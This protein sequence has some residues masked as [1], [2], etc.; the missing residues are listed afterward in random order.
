MY[1]RITVGHTQNYTSAGK[2]GQ[3]FGIQFLTSGCVID[4][5]TLRITSGIRIA[6][7]PVPSGTASPYP[8]VYGDLQNINNIFHIHNLS[9]DTG[10]SSNPDILDHSD[11]YIYMKYADG[12]TPYSHNVKLFQNALKEIDTDN[13]VVIY[14]ANK[15]KNP[16]IFDLCTIQGIS[17]SNIKYI[18]C[19]NFVGGNGPRIILNTSDTPN[20]VYDSS[21]N[22]YDITGSR[23]FYLSILTNSQSSATWLNDSYRDLGS[24]SNTGVYNVT[25]AQLDANYI[26]STADVYYNG[27]IIIHKTHNLEDLL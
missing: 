10:G 12:V 6:T 13:N 24:D 22:K 17:T 19:Y 3:C 7:Y 11:Y 8:E 2:N 14:D 26:I 4:M 5:N 27:N 16:K 20:V 21:D 15:L 23:A 18:G 25:Q 1:F 9:R